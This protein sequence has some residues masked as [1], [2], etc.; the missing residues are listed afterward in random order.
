MDCATCRELLSAQ[1][2]GEE[3]P[4]GEASLTAHLHG[5]AACRAHQRRL[6]PLNRQVRVRGAEPVPDLRGRIVRASVVRYRLAGLRGARLGLL[7]VGLVLLLLAA[8]T[9]LF[10]TT[11]T[12]T[13][14]HLTRELAAFDAALAVGFVLAAWRPSRAAG[15]LPTA[16]VFTAVLVSIAAVDLERGSEV[17][18]LEPHHLC[19]VAGL[20]LLWRVAHRMA[21]PETRQVGLA[22]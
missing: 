18:L 16:A 10:H 19:E 14:H 13:E 21:H 20:F 9:A 17:A 3:L 8:P 7:C 4:G 15:L 5:C 11:G 6:A 2:D 12:M 1:L 22:A